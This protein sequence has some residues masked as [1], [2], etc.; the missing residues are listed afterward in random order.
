M[1]PP[2]LFFSQTNKTCI[3]TTK[4]IADS[5]AA[6][7]NSLNLTEIHFLHLLSEGVKEITLTLTL[8]YYANNVLC[9]HCFN[10]NQTQIL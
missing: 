2:L 10:K 4:N 1:G 8:K 5:S 6:L 3:L 9:I 7:G